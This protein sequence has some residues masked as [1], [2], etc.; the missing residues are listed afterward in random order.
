MLIAQVSDVHLG[1][2]PGGV[3]EPNHRRLVAVIA[4]LQRSRPVPDMLFMTGDLTEHG[5]VASYEA[6]RDAMADVGFPVH[7]MLGNHDRRAGFAQIWPE[8]FTDGF[9]QYVVDTHTLRVIVLDTLEEGRHGGGF[10]DRRATWLAA[11]LAEAPDRPTLVM[12]HHPPIPVGIAW[13]DC[14]PAEPWIARLEASLAGQSQV[15]GLVTGHLH[16]AIASSWQQLPVVICPST[17]PGLSLDLTPIDPTVPDGRGM[18]AD[19]APAYALHRWDGERLVTHF[20][21]ATEAVLVSYTPAMQPMVAGMADEQGSSA[22][23][24]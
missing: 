20:A 5:D 7:Y 2:A 12:L 4:A 9:L 3:D 22:S 10:C 16:R 15:V 24:D 18:I 17:S 11:R 14:D 8:R 1:F 19:D 21:T 23:P 13:M 6:V